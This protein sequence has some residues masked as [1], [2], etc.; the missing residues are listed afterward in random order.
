MAEKVDARVL[1]ET[2][3]FFLE[4]AREVECVHGI[5]NCEQCLEESVEF[6]MHVAEALTEYLAECKS[7]RES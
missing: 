3:E 5:L 2:I 6:G 7:R 1:A 4:I